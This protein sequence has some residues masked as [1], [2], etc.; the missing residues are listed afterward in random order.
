MCSWLR[1]VSL[2]KKKHKALAKC[3]NSFQRLQKTWLKTKFSFAGFRRRRVRKSSKSSSPDQL[4]TEDIQRTK[5]NDFTFLFKAF[6]SKTSILN[7]SKEVPP[8]ATLEVLVQSL[9]RRVSASTSAPAPSSP[10]FCCNFWWR[11]CCLCS[12]SHTHTFLKHYSSSKS[13]KLT[14]TFTTGTRYCTYFFSSFNFSLKFLF[15]FYWSPL[16]FWLDAEKHKKKTYFSP[17]KSLKNGG[18]L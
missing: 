8:L 6:F 10:S 5:D 9:L 3:T 11:F 13:C 1:E 16:V 14:F 2:A 18:K 7:Y 4:H 12:I 15:I 17:F